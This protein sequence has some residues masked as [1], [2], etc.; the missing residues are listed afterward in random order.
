M[1]AYY[2]RDR[3][4]KLGQENSARTGKFPKQ[5]RGILEQIGAEENRSAQDQKFLLFTFSSHFWASRYSA[6]FSL[7]EF[8]EKKT[9]ITSAKA[10]WI[11]VL[12]SIALSDIVEI[13][14]TEGKMKVDIENMK[15]E[16]PL[17]WATRFNKTETV[18]TLLKHG[19]NVNKRNDKGN[20]PIYWAVKYN[21]EETVDALLAQSDLNIYCFKPV[22]EAT[23]VHLACALGR[24]R[25][26][27]K[28]VRHG[29]KVDVHSPVD[30][31][32]CLHLA[33][34]AGHL[35]VVAMLLQNSSFLVHAFCNL[36]L[37]NIL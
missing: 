32:T 16:T 9:R 3:R 4:V 7:I 24:K 18:Q 34:A 5:E 23:L 17:L 15:N 29:A 12:F 27:E 21:N 14:L 2:L 31:S 1:P 37:K 20:S 6:L 33:A 8:S 28:L 10:K 35:P 22:P 19:A 11:F 26:A 25:L 36:G 13:L 30:G